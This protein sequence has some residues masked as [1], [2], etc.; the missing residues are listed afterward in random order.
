MATRLL[1]IGAILIAGCIHSN[2]DSAELIDT[3]L[4][5]VGTE[6]ILYS[7]IMAAIG[8]ALPEI[9]RTSPSVQERD[10]RI[11]E[12]VRSALEES[13]QSK[14]LYREAIRSGLMVS[15]ESVESE[16]E[17]IR[18]RFDTPEDFL[19]AL[20]ESGETMSDFREQTRKRILAS[21]MGST[22]LRELE[23]DV[24][25]SESEV[26]Q[27]YEDNKEQFMRSERV[28][29]RQ[30]Q[31]RVNKD[32]TARAK[33]AARL[34]LLKEEIED[35][36]AFEDLARL[37]SQ[38]PGAEDGGIIGWVERGDLRPELEEALFGLKESELSDVITSPFG[39]HLLTID[40]HQEA[41]LADLDEARTFIEPELRAQ[42]AAVK[43]D[44]WYGD[45]RKRSQVRVYLEQLM[46]DQPD[47][48]VQGS[49][50]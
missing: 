2:A 40:A 24:V 16:I 10:R 21:Y 1:S 11:G 8:S 31:L 36:A 15:D 9:Q 17:E 50:P 5:N 42:A 14:L 6:V 19:K 43:F 47:D 12:L 35:G 49:T 32:E 23:N 45:L 18:D 26:A 34:Q 13:I 30:I 25:V 46:A 7:D 22:R 20:E 29:A 33:A 38:V 4:A 27:F 37:H 39:V 48:S 28:R 41:G 3:V 44:T